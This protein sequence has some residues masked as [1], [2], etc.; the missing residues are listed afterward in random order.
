[1]QAQCNCSS[2]L[3]QLLQGVGEQTDAAEITALRSK[4]F[5]YHLSFEPLPNV[6]FSKEFISLNTCYVSMYLLL[7]IYYRDHK[8]AHRTHQPAQ[9]IS[10]THTPEG[11]VLLSDCQ[12]TISLLFFFF[13]TVC[14]CPK[15]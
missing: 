4:V 7:C 15:A 2:T 9:I 8:H 6:V 12:I 5:R 3:K 11:D 10:A 14:Y 1:M 13:S